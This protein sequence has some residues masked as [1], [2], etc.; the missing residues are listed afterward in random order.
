MRRLSLLAYLIFALGLILVGCGFPAEDGISDVPV[1]PT[2]TIVPSATEVPKLP[3]Q[4]KIT[5]NQATDLPDATSIPDN[6]DETIDCGETFCQMVWYGILKRPVPAGSQITIDPAYPYASTLNRTLEPHHGV[7]FPRSYG[8]PVLAAL[9]GEV[10]YS[11]VDDLVVLGPYTGFYG[12]VIIIHH[13]G[14]FN[15]RDLF[16]LYA[17]LSVIDVAVGDQVISGEVI[18]QVGATGAAD[19]SHL[20]FEVRLDQNEYQRTTNP[21]L[22]FSPSR[23]N[24]SESAG[25]LAGLIT[26]RYGETLSEFSMTLEKIGEDST[27]EARFYPQTYYFLG[28]NGHPELGEN[29]VVP[30][31]PAG[32]YRLAFIS[33]RL[34]E[35]F[36]EL[37]SGSLGFIKLQL[38]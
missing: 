3:A 29:F 5:Q 12:N 14:I 26:N 20:H 36:F 37:Q 23:G 13:P 27:I 10:V 25:V 32:N 30:D 6:A 22:W 33:G 2:S 8:T 17:H 11:G 34:Y 28:A 38:D 21:V 7:E 35:I 18:G 1:M 19:G 31:I 15:G 4:T 9:D 24:G 16:T